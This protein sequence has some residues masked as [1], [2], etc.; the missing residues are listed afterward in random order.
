MATKKPAPPK[1]PLQALAEDPVQLLAHLLWQRRIEAPELSIVITPK[2]REGLGQCLEYL[3]KKADVRAFV[4]GDRVLVQMVDAGSKPVVRRIVDK[5][6]SGQVVKAPDDVPVEWKDGAV[7]TEPGDTI[8]GVGDCIRPIENNEQ[9]YDAAARAERI[10]NIKSGAARL[11]AE[12]K[13]SAAAGTFST[14]MVSEVC[15]ALMTLANA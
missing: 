6:V 4:R 8:V 2:D 12:V 15:D 13:S 11:A 5:L 10:R 14:A 3:E 1:D 7:V 9:D